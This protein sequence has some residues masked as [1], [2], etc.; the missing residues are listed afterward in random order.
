MA[1]YKLLIIDDEW[2]RRKK[3]Y[4]TVLE[5]PALFDLDFLKNPSELGELQEKNPDGYIID[6]F[7]SENG[8]QTKA[9]EVLEK[10]IS[11]NPKPVFLVTE[12]LNEEEIK[13]EI[14][15]LLKNPIH[16]N[17]FFVW[18]DFTNAENRVSRNENAAATRW[19]IQVE[20]D[21][22]HQRSIF[23]PEPDQTLRILH[24]SDMQFDDPGT[25]TKEFLAED[26]IA[27]SLKNDNKS[28]DFLFISGDISYSG[29]PDEY[30]SAL[31]WFDK[32]FLP[33]ISNDKIDQWRERIVIVPGNHDVNFRLTSCDY[34]DF[35]FNSETRENML[36]RS[37]TNYQDHKKFGLTPFR[38]FASKLSPD[39]N[40]S[41]RDSMCWVS[42]RFIGLGI[43]IILLNSVLSISSDNPSDVTID[44]EMLRLLKRDIHSLRADKK[45]FRILIS[46]HGPHPRD[47]LTNAISNWQEVENF[48]ES[49]EIDLFIHG[50]G[51]G[52]E[53]NSMGGTTSRKQMPIVMAPSTHLNGQLRSEDQLRGFNLI[54]LYRKNNQITG[55]K[56][57]HYEIKGARAK[58]GDSSKRY[59]IIK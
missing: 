5:D 26:A 31:S 33:Q 37:A 30:L 25:S 22:W 15:E 11:I 7:L 16:I 14:S 43:Q 35:N 50:H 4:Q 55:S 56:I 1:K 52:Y 28:P 8:W 12:H 3:A 57:F 39:K 51:H 2:D 29:R 24:I 6:I 46:H 36:V 47:G 9:S 38:N 59:T 54:E 18:D 23:C 34:Y 58:I 13:D 40:W 41:D 42:N 45:P 20:L 48:I 49:S 21:R 17:H 32:D 10:Y 27:D 44:K 19:K 53:D